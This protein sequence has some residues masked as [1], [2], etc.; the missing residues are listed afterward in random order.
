MAWQDSQALGSKEVKILKNIIGHKKY[1]LN[2]NEME[3]VSKVF[4]AHRNETSAELK[5]RVYLTEPMK[6]ILRKEKKVKKPIIFR[7][8]FEVIYKAG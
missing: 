4:N 2:N 7:L 8:S 1:G 6:K 5:T 3:I